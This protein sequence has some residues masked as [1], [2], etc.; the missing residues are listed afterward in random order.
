M[1]L[2][3]NS[4]GGLLISLYAIAH[5]D[6]G[7]R[8]VLDS[9]APPIKGFMDD[10]NDEILRRMK[11]VYTPQLERARITGRPELWLKTDEPVG[12]CREFYTLVLR[13]YTYARSLYGFKGD[14]CAGR[15]ESVRLQRNREPRRMA[16]PRRL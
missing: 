13:T 14:V 4:W 11:E 12:V 8:L 5:P 3:G 16:K 2:R 15:K 9:P 10:I 7:E 6:R 1:A